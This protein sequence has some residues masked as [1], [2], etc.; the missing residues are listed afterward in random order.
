MLTPANF[1]PLS[2]TQNGQDDIRAVRTAVRVPIIGIRKIWTQDVPVYITPTFPDAEAVAAAGADIVALDGTARPRAG[3]AK[4]EELIPRIRQELSLPVMADVSTFEEGVRAAQLGAHVVATT[5]SGYTGGTPPEDPDLDLLRRL[6]RA[7]TV[8][9]VAEGRYRTP[10][11][12]RKA[13]DAGAFAVV[14]GRAITDALSITQ[15]FVAS[16]KVSRK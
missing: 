9:V 14:V 15:S 2:A 3:G 12:V 4:I 11:Q 13:L 1:M 7:L 8:P 16:A 6:A 10:D 5:L